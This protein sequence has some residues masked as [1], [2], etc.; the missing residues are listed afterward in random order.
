MF[1]FELISVNV[2]R[3]IMIPI[4]MLMLQQ[5]YIR[6]EIYFLTPFFVNTVFFVE[7]RLRCTID[8]IGGR[9]S[10]N[11]YSHAFGARDLW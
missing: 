7:D 2:R 10:L 1:T 4:C 9:P 3:H 6:G 5:V 8:K 11:D